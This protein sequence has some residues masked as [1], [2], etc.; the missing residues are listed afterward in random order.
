MRGNDLRLWLA[1]SKRFP[2]IRD[3]EGIVLWKV[4][5]L[6]AAEWLAGGPLIDCARKGVKAV[7]LFSLLNE[8]DT[9]PCVYKGIKCSFDCF[10]TIPVS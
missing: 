8:K 7:E 1:A 3:R 4:R 6:F 5:S 10:V 9:I 2:P